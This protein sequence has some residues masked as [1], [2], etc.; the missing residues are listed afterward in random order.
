MMT[1]YLSIYLVGAYYE[2]AQEVWQHV[3]QQDSV[4][5]SHP[6][7]YL[8]HTVKYNHSQHISSVIKSD[9]YVFRRDACFIPTQH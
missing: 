5:T 8:H 9:T 4:E 1:V 2:Y 6:I 3:G 7:L